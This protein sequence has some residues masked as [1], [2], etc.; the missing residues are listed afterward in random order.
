MNYIGR[1][2]NPFIS[3]QTRTHFLIMSAFIDMEATSSKRKSGQDAIA[4]AAKKVKRFQLQAIKWLVTWPR[5]DISIQAMEKLLRTKGLKPTEYRGVRE[6]KDGHIHFHIL[7]NWGVKKITSDPR[8]FDTEQG[9][10]G[11]MEGARDYNQSYNY[12]LK[13]KN[14]DDEFFG[15]LSAPEKKKI[16]R[17]EVSIALDQCKTLEEAEKLWNQLDP[18]MK[19]FARRA[20]REALADRF[21]GETAVND[22][23]DIVGAGVLTLP[24]AVQ[25]WIESALSI[26]RPERQRSLVLLGPSKVG[27]TSMA[28][29][30]G[31]HLYFQ[32]DIHKGALQQC[33]RIQYAIFDDPDANEFVR[34]YKSVIG[35]QLDFTS[36]EKYHPKFTVHWDGLAAIVIMNNRAYEEFMTRVDKEWWQA[37]TTECNII[38][39]VFPR[40]VVD[41]IELD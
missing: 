40:V 2:T 12:V 34:L 31:K 15:Q 8:Y 28:R 19:W 13:G 10:H 38:Q 27:K 6:I 9:H 26:P 41:G 11:H 29:S 18:S 14:E 21:L 37:N 3:Q 24:E 39:S 20:Q 36:T 25:D 23:R 35:G 4:P 33:H 7:I 5:C 16:S 32:G 17:A 30:L 22:P 1:R